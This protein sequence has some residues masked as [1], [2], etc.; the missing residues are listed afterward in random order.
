MNNKKTIRILIIGLLVLITALIIYKKVSNQDT[1]VKIKTIS[2]AVDTIQRE[3]LIQGIIVPSKEI[4][5]KS[6]ISGI[7][8]RLFVKIGDRVSKGDII[9]KIK[10]VTDPVSYERLER[11]Y[12]I[13][14]ANYENSKVKYERMKSLFADKAISTP[15]FEDAER[16]YIV[17]K[18]ELQSTKK[19]LD[20]TN[21]NLN[22]NDVNN[23]VRATSDGTI[24]EL[25][26]KVGG[27]VNAR[28]SMQDGTTLANIANLN[29]LLFQGKVLESEVSYLK[30]GMEIELTIGALKDIKLKGVIILISPKGNASDGSVKF[31]FWADVEIPRD[32][33]IE[34]RAGYSANA[35]IILEKK[36][37]ALLLDEKYVDFKNDSAFVEV[38]DTVKNSIKNTYITTGLSN[39]RQ[40]EITGGIDKST[41][42]KLK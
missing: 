7:V 22:T 10:V 15:E 19:E 13:A 3:I 27:P 14:E 38:A 36:V 2:P 28:S 20:F 25:P 1:E 24:L 18:H 8:E 29:S 40:I 32:S 21:E 16:Q 42:I 9:A 4:L 37:N 26:V 31:D 35:N 39:G 41:L 17:S 30:P 34:L 11:Q 12:N 33:K 6:Q 23:L 5:I